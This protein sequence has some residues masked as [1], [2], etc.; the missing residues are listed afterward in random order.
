MIGLIAEADIKCPMLSKPNICRH[1][2]FFGGKFKGQE[3]HKIVALYL[4]TP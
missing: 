4:E 1:V 3:L 2:S